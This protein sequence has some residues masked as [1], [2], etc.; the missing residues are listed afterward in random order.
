VFF[1]DAQRLE[2]RVDPDAIP[3]TRLWILR[4]MLAKG[5]VPLKDTV[6]CAQGAYNVDY[7]PRGWGLTNF[8]MHVHRKP[9]ETYL[10]L[11]KK[12]GTQS[13]SELF[14][15]GI[16]KQPADLQAAWEAYIKAIEPKTADELAN[17]AVAA[18]GIYLDQQRAEDYAQRSV[19]LAAGSW[20]SQAA[21]G[22]AKL[23]IARLSGRRE[24]AVAAV[25]AFDTACELAK[26]DPVSIKARVKKGQS[27]S[28]WT[29]LLASRMFACFEA[30]DGERAAACACELLE[31]D[32]A[33]AYAY[34]MLA[35]LGAG[36]P[37][38][39]AEA[40]TFLATAQDIGNDHLVRWCAARVAAATG[41]LSEAAN[42]LAEAAKL[43]RLGLG[44]AWYPAE[45][46]R[47]ATPKR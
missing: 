34:G 17:A 12:G 25:A 22:A 1:E 23:A 37:E 20:R 29:D 42:L 10:M 32:E 8:L 46:K 9:Y 24:S 15:K 40:A 16:G 11:L 13:N 39:G 45:A 27:L 47:L 38:D 35:V 26:A 41:R 5:P 28:I 4:D 30:G 2:D 7:Y 19:D 44:R 14:V 31:V 21:L 6:D 33:S 18:L 43:D 36:D 3:W